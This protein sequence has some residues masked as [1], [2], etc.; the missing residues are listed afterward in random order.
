MTAVE[1]RLFGPFEVYR[2]SSLVAD[3]TGLRQALLARLL[4]S[5][6][7]P[8]G[9][10]Q[11]V[12][13][14]WGEDPPR[15]A[16]NLVQGYVS[17]WRSVLDPGRGH[18]ASGD[19]LTSSGG[20]YT[21][22]VAEEECDLLR[23]HAGARAGREAV[24]LGDLYRARQLLQRALVERRDTALLGFTHTMLEQF[25]VSYEAQWLD[26]VEAA[27][28]VELRLGRP[29]AALAYVQP[30]ISAHPLRE[31]LVALQMLA[32]YRAGRQADALEAYDRA[33][34]AL[35]DELGVDPSVRLGRLHMDIL[36]QSG[37]LARE[38]ETETETARRAPVLPLRL[39]SFIGREELGSQVREQLETHRLVTLTGSAG[40][41]KTRL[42]V[43][44][45]AAV[46]ATRERR[47]AFVDLAPVRDSD[48]LWQSVANVLGA[49]PP[50]SNEPDE[51][52]SS[53]GPGV[54]QLLVLDNM[55]HLLQAAPSIA[56]VLAQ[57]PLLSLLATS[58]SHSASWGSSSSP[59][60]PCRHHDRGI[61]MRPFSTARPC[62]SSWHA[63]RR[64]TP[65]SSYATKTWPS[66]L[67]SA[68][69]WT[70]YP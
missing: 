34:H 52:V 54:A 64:P 36:S 60:R 3:G 62:V 69:G 7:H 4:V 44:V 49:H 1:F 67:G 11:L 16:A 30:L 51:I 47:V 22:H 25:A 48:L 20:G 68:S 41:G 57:A 6:N 50:A 10:D 12:A 35:A 39:T 61:G 53:L 32:L 2:S 26:T 17:Y 43:E 29:S 23:F 37:E 70:V 14:V 28:D 5:A 31:S 55:E 63:R 66:W 24:A 65:T 56:A 27:A 13:A 46:A 45:A 9:R 8:V 59:C 19:R 18:R 38:T 42:A 40:S 15:S 58:A 21:L 33:R